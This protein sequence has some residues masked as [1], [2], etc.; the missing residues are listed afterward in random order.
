M[1]AAGRIDQENIGANGA[2]DEGVRREP[3]V[4]REPG[5]RRE[6]GAGRAGSRGSNPG[7]VFFWL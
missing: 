1:I 2:R 5:S 7:N 3:G 4:G 6:P